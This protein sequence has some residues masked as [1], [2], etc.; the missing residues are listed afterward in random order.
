MEVI[1]KFTIMEIV[2]VPLS[3][4]IG[5]LMAV[6]NAIIMEIAMARLG[7]PLSEEVRK[8]FSMITGI[9][10]AHL[11]FLLSKTVVCF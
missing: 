7:P 3:G 10:M 6:Q 1:V 9:V 11:F 4:L 2:T 8:H 5:S